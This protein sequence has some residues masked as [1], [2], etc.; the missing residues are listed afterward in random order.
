MMTKTMMKMM[1][2]MEMTA[3]AIAIITPMKWTL[4]MKAGSRKKVQKHEHAYDM[5][6]DDG[7]EMLMSVTCQT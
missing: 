2:K 3:M 5:D 1:T 6:S 7:E 4:M